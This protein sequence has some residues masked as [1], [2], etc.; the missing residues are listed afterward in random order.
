GDPDLQ[1]ALDWQ[2]K[3]RPNQGWARR[4]DPGFETSM[5]F[6]QASKQK[7]ADELAETER[8]QGEEAERTKRELAQAH[9]LA[10]AERQKAEE[11]RRRLEEQKRETSKLRRLLGG[12]IVVSLF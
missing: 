5:A 3:N 8:R 10:E 11:Q 4:Y 12:L 6:L 1:L 7:R 2:Q 9:A